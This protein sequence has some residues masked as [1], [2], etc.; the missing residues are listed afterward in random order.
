MSTA[1]PVGLR[2]RASG[3]V[4]ATTG[5]GPRNSPLVRGWQICLEI[6]RHR[7]N[8]PPTRPSPVAS[9]AYAS[10]R[11]RRRVYFGFALPSPPEEKVRQRFQ[12]S[13]PR[14]TH[15][16]SVRLGAEPLGGF[17]ARGYKNWV[18]RGG[19]QEPSC[20]CPPARG[21]PSVCPILPSPKDGLP[22]PEG[23]GHDHRRR[24]LRPTVRRRTRPPRHRASPRAELQ[25][26]QL[27]FQLMSAT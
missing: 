12:R 21:E 4:S 14:S 9:H 17:S 5:H 7:C 2:A 23:F 15:Q 22:E 11:G 18:G 10:V 24:L 26:H 25:E 20:G 16:I 27:P 13:S 3:A 6:V 8:L 1:K 19:G